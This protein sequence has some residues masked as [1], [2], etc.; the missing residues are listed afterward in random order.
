MERC[1][2][3][4]HASSARVLFDFLHKLAIH[5]LKA[6]PLIDND[7]SPTSFIHVFAVLD[8][9]IVCGNH[10]GWPRVDVIY[11]MVFGIHDSLS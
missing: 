4:D 7:V 1:S 9:D 10:N 8:D 11:V 6:M 2:S 5:V 3:Q